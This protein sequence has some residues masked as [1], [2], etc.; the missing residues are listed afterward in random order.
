LRVEP[1]KRTPGVK[2]TGELVTRP[3]QSLA[4]LSDRR[5]NLIRPKAESKRENVAGSGTGGL[6]STV[7]VMIWML[8]SHADDYQI[9]ADIPSAGFAATPLLQH[10][11][12]ACGGGDAGVTP[13]YRYSASGMRRSRERVLLR[14]KVCLTDRI[15]LTMTLHLL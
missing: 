4:V 12:K 15:V 5:K 8:S 3:N 10:E 9:A 7:V 14:R 2:R 11:G 1:K 6:G 13:V